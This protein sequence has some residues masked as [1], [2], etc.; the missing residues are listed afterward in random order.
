MLGPDSPRVSGLYRRRASRGA[1]CRTKA[2]RPLRAKARA[3]KAGSAWAA[4][5]PRPATPD[6]AILALVRFDIVDRVLEGGDLF[7]RVVGDFDAEFFFERHHQLDDVEAVGAQIV[8]EARF[9]GDFVGVDAPMFADN[10]FNIFGRLAHAQ[11][12]FSY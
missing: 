11:F 10:I 1:A 5:P 2:S 8:D 7:R 4:S 3:R 9:F 12:L 6:R